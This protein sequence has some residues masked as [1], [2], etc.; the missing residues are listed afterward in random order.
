VR[1]RFIV[2]LAFG[3]VGLAAGIPVGS[4]LGLS[5]LQGV[6]ACTAGGLFIGYL[7]SIFLDIFV[8]NTT[9]TTEN[10]E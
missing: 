9:N 7:L 5:N 10:P 6:I 2:S 8:T 1:K 4:L 3:A